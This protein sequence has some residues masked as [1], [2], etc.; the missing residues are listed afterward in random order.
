MQIKHVSS[1]FRK[2][3]MA[4]NEERKVEFRRKNPLG[5]TRDQEIWLIL[6]MA[7]ADWKRIRHSSHIFSD[8]R[9]ARCCGVYRNGAR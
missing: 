4:H 9:R 7:R 5:F 1:I 8:E 2:N 3:F 6:T